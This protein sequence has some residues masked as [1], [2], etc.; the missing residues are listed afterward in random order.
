[1]SDKYQTHQLINTAQQHQHSEQPP[2][3]INDIVLVDLFHPQSNIIGLGLMV[4][5]FGEE[6]L[7]LIGLIFILIIYPILHQL[8]PYTSSRQ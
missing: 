5:I 3:N 6:M 4:D 7:E 2:Y 8:H 1:M